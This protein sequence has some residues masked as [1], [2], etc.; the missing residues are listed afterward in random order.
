MARKLSVYLNDGLAYE[1]DR[2]KRL[3]GHQRLFLDKMDEDMNAGISMAGEF[4]AI[5]DEKVRMHYVAI[6]LVQGILADNQALITATGSYI[7]IRYAAL[8]EI[9]AQE[10]GEQVGMTFVFD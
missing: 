6:K 1:Y 10:E 7:S 8:K 2:R 4:I 3:P 5:P 9:H